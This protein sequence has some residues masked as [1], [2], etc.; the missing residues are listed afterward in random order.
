MAAGWSPAGCQ[1]ACNVNI[2]DIPSDITH[3][4]LRCMHRI[5][6]HDKHGQTFYRRQDFSTVNMQLAER[7]QRVQPSPTLAI[8]ARAAEMKAAGHDIKIG[9]ASC[10]ERARETGRGRAL[11][12]R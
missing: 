10:R 1:S 6:Y 8:T 5:R 11:E 4:R 2:S 9:R 7:V 3:V 12:E